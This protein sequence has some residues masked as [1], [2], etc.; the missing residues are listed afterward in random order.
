VIQGLDTSVVLRLLIAAPVDQADAARRMFE[1]QAPAS[2]ALSDLVVGESYFALRHHYAVPHARAVAALLDL[3]S[4]AR[5]IS[6]GV[7]RTALANMPE[8]ESGAGFMDRLI[9]ASYQAD[10]FGMLTFDRAAARLPG[11]QLLAR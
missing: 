5:V 7:A 11:A 3:L 8:R 9:H 10:D 6:T 2:F 4:D 1:A